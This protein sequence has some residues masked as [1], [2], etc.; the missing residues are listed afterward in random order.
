MYLRIGFPHHFRNDIGMNITAPASKKRNDN[1]LHIV[2]ISTH[3]CRSHAMINHTGAF[4]RLRYPHGRCMDQSLTV[5]SGIYNDTCPHRLFT[6]QMLQYV[7][8]NTFWK[9]FSKIS[10]NSPVIS[11]IHQAI[12]IGR[13]NNALNRIVVHK[14]LKFSIYHFHIVQPIEIQ[15]CIPCG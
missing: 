6:I 10:R 11:A 12:S 5:S 1:T 8:L 15:F 3:Q 9:L 2:L 14:V 13:R 7:S 4:D